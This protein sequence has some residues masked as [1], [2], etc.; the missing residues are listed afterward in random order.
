MPRQPNLFGFPAPQ[1]PQQGNNG[2]AGVFGRLARNGAQPPLL[3]GHNPGHQNGNVQGWVPG[4]VPGVVIQYNIHYQNTQHQQ[5]QVHPPA[6]TPT[7]RP[8]PPFS[9]FVGPDQ[10]WRPWRVDRWLD[11]EMSRSRADENSANSGSN[12]A[13]SESFITGTSVSGGSQ[14]PAG[15]SGRGSS[16]HTPANAAIFHN[17][18]SSSTGNTTS[19]LTLPSLIPLDPVHVPVAPA[20]FRAH[21]YTPRP[22]S[23]TRTV[24]HTATER[25]IFDTELMQMDHLTREAIDERLRIF[26]NVSVTID[27][28]VA[29]LVRVRGALPMSPNTALPSTG[30]GSGAP[31]P[32]QCEISPY[33]MAKVL[34]YH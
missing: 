28:C 29:D 4:P 7:P 1:H 12:Q 19:P 2:L 17:E 22:R 34:I 24:S 11:Q 21:D 26:E 5:G 31:D 20:V 16:Q 33:L 32:I 30:P 14:I 13:V 6:A 9:G 18:S 25:I 27:R 15:T 3:T 23:P 8:L 10:N